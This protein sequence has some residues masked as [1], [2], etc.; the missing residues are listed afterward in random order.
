MMSS[1]PRS[2]RVAERFLSGMSTAVAAGPRMDL[3]EYEKAD[4]TAQ[5]IIDRVVFVTHHTPDT[6]P[7][8][9]D[10]RSLDEDMS[11]IGS[12]RAAL[13]NRARAWPKDR[14]VSWLENFSRSGSI[15]DLRKVVEKHPLFI[16]IKNPKGKIERKTTGTEA[17]FHRMQEMAASPE[18]SSVRGKVIEALPFQKNPALKL[19]ERLERAQKQ[20]YQEYDQLYKAL[21]TPSPEM[22]IEASHGELL[23]KIQDHGICV[24]GMQAVPMGHSDEDVVNNL[25]ADDLASLQAKYGVGD[26]WM[27]FHAVVHPFLRGQ[28]LG[29]QMYDTLIKR[30]RQNGK[31]AYLVANRCYQYAGGDLTSPDAKRVWDSLRRRYPSAGFSLALV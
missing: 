21:R 4:E 16:L 2:N 1:A 31:P 27:V 13:I 6:E 3:S 14:W 12:G 18:Y 5:A 11:H 23:V 30:I 9:D 10:T 25:C 7:L 24:G 8:G 29:S 26:V 17:D 28:H 15:D 19:L 20:R 22:E